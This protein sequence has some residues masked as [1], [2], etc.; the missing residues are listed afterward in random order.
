M[1][2]IN[3]LNTIMSDSNVKSLGLTYEDVAFISALTCLGIC[4]CLV[5]FINYKTE[6]RKRRYLSTIAKTLWNFNPNEQ[7]KIDEMSWQWR[8]LLLS[9]VMLSSLIVSTTVHS[10]KYEL[11][12]KI[13]CTF[14][15][16]WIVG[17]SVFWHTNVSPHLQTT[18]KTIPTLSNVTSNNNIDNENSEIRDDRLPVSIITGYLGAGKTTLLKKILHK[19]NL[20]ENN[21]IFKILVIENEIGDEGKVP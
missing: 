12:L 18:D 6:T 9:G 8:K 7:I 5:L 2:L 13:S 16:V 4:G 3:I 17:I 21:S 19:T 11:A 14:L 10:I 20:D 1:K 15:C